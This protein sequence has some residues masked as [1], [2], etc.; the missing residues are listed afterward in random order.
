[1]KPA[2]RGNQKLAKLMDDFASD[3]E[4]ENPGLPIPNSTKPW[5]R[6]FRLYLDSQDTVPA[7]MPLIKWWGVCTA[8]LLLLFEVT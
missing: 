7:G 6:E 8:R 5:Q 3:E 1:M 4:V 2:P